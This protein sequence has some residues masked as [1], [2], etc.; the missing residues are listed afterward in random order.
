VWPLP[1]CLLE[2]L[3]VSTRQL[4]LIQSALA[5]GCTRSFA[6][7][8]N[9]FCSGSDDKS[10]KVF[11]FYTLKEEMVRDLSPCDRFGALRAL[12]YCLAFSWIASFHH[13]CTPFQPYV[14]VGPPWP[15][16]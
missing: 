12:A 11:D 3:L 6:P 8:D 9:K 13:T 7:T 15:R 5:F 2:T 1:C 10:V 14:S 16:R 4:S